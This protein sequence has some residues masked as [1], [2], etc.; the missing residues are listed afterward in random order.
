MENQLLYSLVPF[1]K[2]R[3]DKDNKDGTYT[4]TTVNVHKNSN[5]VIIKPIEFNG[6][7]LYVLLKI[8]N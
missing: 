5:Q 8:I 3:I 1:D 4:A 2:I 6:R 7:V